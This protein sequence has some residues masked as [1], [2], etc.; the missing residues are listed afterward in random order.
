MFRQALY[1]INHARC[2]T[3]CV[4]IAGLRVRACSADRLAYL[5]C[6]KLGLLGRDDRRVLEAQ[7][8]PGMRAV[9]VGANLGLTTLMMARLVGPTGSVIALEPDPRLHATL[10]RNIAANDARH[11]TALCAAAGDRTG[12]AMLRQSPLHTGDHRMYAMDGHEGRA[13]VEVDVI[14]LDDV[15]VLAGQA[16][17]FVKIDVQGYE[18]HVL[19]GMEAVMARSPRLCIM[20]EY[21]P[22]KLHAAGSEPAELLARLRERGFTIHQVDARGRM[23]RIESNG[24]IAGLHRPIGRYFLNLLAIRDSA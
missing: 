8:R 7:L 14:R 19:S 5:W 2:W 15:Q 21:T 23:K 13:G 6:H 10:E 9:D 20:F 16:V 17:D 11:V 12:R 4:R 24:A 3:R 1:R 18:A 22:A